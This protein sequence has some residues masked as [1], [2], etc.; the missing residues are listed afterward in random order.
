MQTADRIPVHAMTSRFAKA[1]L[2]IPAFVTVAMFADRIPA[3]AADFAIIHL[4]NA[5]AYVAVTAMKCQLTAFALGVPIAEISWNA[6]PV[7]S[8]AAVATSRITVTAAITAACLR[9]NALA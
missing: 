7:M 5:H 4:E 9:I 8:A 2:K 1:A 3:S 6:A